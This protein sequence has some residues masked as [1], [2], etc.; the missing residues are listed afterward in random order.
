MSIDLIDADIGTTV[1]QVNQLHRLQ[2]LRKTADANNLT[3][4]NGGTYCA[5]PQN[6]ST[7]SEFRRA[8]RLLSTRS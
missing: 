2:T 8:Q 3:K 4:E 7:T 1:D 6:N 5:T